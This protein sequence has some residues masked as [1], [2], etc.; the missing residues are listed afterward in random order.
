MAAYFDAELEAVLTNVVEEVVSK[1]IAVEQIK[2]LFVD[3]LDTTF[4]TNGT[5]RRL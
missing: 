5:G 4:R 2:L 3:W 1:A